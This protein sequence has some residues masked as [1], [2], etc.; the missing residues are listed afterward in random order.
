MSSRNTAY[1]VLCSWCLT[2]GLLHSKD[3]HIVSGGSGEPLVLRGYPL[4]DDAADRALCTR[5]QGPTWNSWQE[6]W[7]HSV[8]PALP[9]PGAFHTELRLSGLQSC[10]AA[11]GISWYTW[12]LLLGGPLSSTPREKPSSFPQLVRELALGGR[13]VE[14]L[15][16]AGNLRTVQRDTCKL[17][18]VFKTSHDGSL[19]PPC[20]CSHC[21]PQVL[22][23]LWRILEQLRLVHNESSLTL[24]SISLL[25]VLHFILFT[26]VQALEL[27][28]LD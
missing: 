16:Q 8:T 5:P 28:C 6:L 2:L 7:A 15:T 23:Y 10:P 3:L 4:C 27:T 25:G 1:P 20:F 18:S 22:G 19:P 17:C 11:A 26:I 9:L 14:V 21:I 12:G 13:S 24:P